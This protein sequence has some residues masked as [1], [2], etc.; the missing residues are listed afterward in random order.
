MS[1]HLNPVHLRHHDVQQDYVWLLFF[2]RG[3]GRFPISGRDDLVFVGREAGPEDIKVVWV[4]VGDEYPRWCP[5]N[6]FL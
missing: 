5:H 6:R 4:I 2:G 1:A 3:K